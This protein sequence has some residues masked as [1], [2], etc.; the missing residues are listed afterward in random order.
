[1]EH[2]KNIWA[3]ILC[4]LLSSVIVFGVARPDAVGAWLA[5]VDQARQTSMDAYWCQVY[6]CDAEI[7][8]FGEMIN[9]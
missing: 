7:N 2:F 5:T 4:V 6:S 1:M 8:E 3:S 9:D